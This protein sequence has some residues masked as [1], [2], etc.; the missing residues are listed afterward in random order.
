MSNGTA[1]L[2]ASRVPSPKSPALRRQV[3]RGILYVVV[4]LLSILF[5][6][7]FFWTVSSSL[8]SSTE[9]FVFPPLWLPKVPQWVNYE[10]AWTRYPFPRWYLNTFEIVILRTAGVVISSCAVAYSFARFRYRGRDLLFVVTLGTMMLP[11]EVSLIPQYILF[12]RLGWINTIRP[13]WVP[14]WLGGGAFNIFLLRQFMMSIPKELDE[15][16][17]IDGASYPYILSMI[18]LPLMK[19]VLAT[20]LVINFISTWNDFMGPLIYLNT[21][22]KLTVSVGLRWFAVSPREGGKP[23]DHLLMAACVMAAVPPII[24]F[25]AAQKQFVQGVVLSGIKG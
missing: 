24:L 1:A 25:F 20:V 4:V 7:P 22:K 14:A 16:A 2:G 15:A 9:V 6:F 13:L 11:S 8:K 19:P 21:A 3:S 10:T 12:Y 23:E 18:L 5:M 17:F